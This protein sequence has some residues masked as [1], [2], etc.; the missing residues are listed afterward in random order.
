[1]RRYEDELDIQQYQG[2]P[3]PAWRL[4]MAAALPADRT[5]TLVLGA[6][7][8]IQDVH[9]FLLL[10][11]GDAGQTHAKAAYPVIAAAYEFHRDKAKS[12]LAK[13]MVLGGCETRE[14][15]GRLELDEQILATWERLFF[16]V[17]QGLEAVGWIYAHVIM[18]EQ[19]NSLLT[20]Q[21]KAAVAGGPDIARAIVN[22]E[23][24][25]AVSVGQKLFERKLKLDLKLT[26]AVELPLSTNREKM[27]FI[28]LNT[29][30]MAQ[31]ERLKLAR[32]KLAMQCAAWSWWQ[33]QLRAEREAAAARAAA[34]PL[35]KLKWASPADA[36]TPS[37]HGEMDTKARV[38]TV[39][40]T[41]APADDRPTTVPSLGNN[42]GRM[43]G[44]TMS[45]HDATQVP[46]ESV[47]STAASIGRARSKRVPWTWRRARASAGCKAWARAAFRSRRWMP[48]IGQRARQAREILGHG[49]RKMAALQ[50]FSGTATSPT[51]DG[52]CRRP[53]AAK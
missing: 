7:K 29:R 27:F 39:Y 36:A 19:D 14:I 12:T 10:C 30:L 20:S 17:R 33:A 1:M 13:I 41:K 4:E 24:H 34:C 26:A 52:T 45:P 50:Q 21:M 2:W 6:E 9:H 42:D 11:Q 8:A 47:A 43:D 35:S 37:L 32:E 18:P 31:E 38:E 44:A 49:N 46:S 23:S 5:N 25:R 15:A 22:L 51:R 53:P 3:G 48:R 16:D 40:E 28:R